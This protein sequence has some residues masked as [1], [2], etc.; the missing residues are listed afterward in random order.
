MS[1]PRR[2]ARREVIPAPDE[3]SL[4]R[5][6]APEFSLPAYRYV[7]GCH[8]HPNRD[9]AGHSFGHPAPRIPALDPSAWERERQYLLGVDLF[10]RRY[11]WEAH[12]AWESVWRACSPD[13]TE[14]RFLQGLILVSAA[15]LKWCEGR[16]AGLE[17]LH[18]KALRCFAPVLGEA[19]GAPSPAAFMGIALRDWLDEVAEAMRRL[20][21][22]APGLIDHSVVFPV[23]RLAAAPPE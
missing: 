22:R 16:P 11:F 10:N 21:E 9:P 7:P 3:A 23:I 12:E 6:Y 13:S 18:A 4:P 20:P 5:R 2:D 15:F 19:P 1:A 8:P 14:G 17:R